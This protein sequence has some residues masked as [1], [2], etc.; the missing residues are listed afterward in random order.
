ML[1]VLDLSEYVL[2]LLDVESGD[3][4]SNLKLQKILYYLQGHFLAVF[5]KPLFEEKIEAWKFGP[6]IGNIYQKYKIYDKCIPTDNLEYD[7]SNL[8]EDEINFIKNIYDIYSNFSAKRLVEMTHSEAPFRNAFGGDYTNNE[9]TKES[10][11]DFF[12]KQIE[13]HFLEETRKVIR[14]IDFSKMGEWEEYKFGTN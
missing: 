2:S 14:E 9:I 3:T 1:N 7:I 6:V 10:M 5:D 11:K 12:V 4:I 8:T 13:N